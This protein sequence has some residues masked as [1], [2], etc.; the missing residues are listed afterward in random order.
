MYEHY[1]TLIEARIF[2]LDVFDQEIPVRVVRHD[3]E[4]RVYRVGAS[5]HCK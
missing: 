5:T 2:V 3:N 4:T 1:L